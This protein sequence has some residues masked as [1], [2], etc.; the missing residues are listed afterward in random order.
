M[1]I[2]SLAAVF[3]LAKTMLYTGKP[4]SLAEIIRSGLSISNMEIKNFQIGENL[5]FKNI[6]SV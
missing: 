3:L 2:Y 4:R 5:P 1:N 6:S